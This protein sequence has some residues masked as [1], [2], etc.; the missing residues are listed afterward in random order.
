[1]A[2][3]TFGSTFLFAGLHLSRSFI[4][5]VQSLFE[6]SAYRP[7][8]LTPVALF[9]GP[10]FHTN[11]FHFLG[12]L[13]SLYFFGAL[14]EALLPRLTFAVIFGAGLWLSNP[15]TQA[16]LQ[17]W[18]PRIDP[19]G[20]AR[21]LAEW[22]YGMSNGVYALVGA[23]AAFL[24]R[25]GTVLVP[26]ILNAVFL[27]FA[28]NSWLSVHHLVGLFLGFSL[29]RIQFFSSAKRAARYA[30]RRARR[31]FSSSQRSD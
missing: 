19:T 27:I 26:F 12:N 20:Y 9:F 11:S 3:I 16:I 24:I 10:L 4:P 29:T 31:V 2:K 18:L 7:E 5:E 1:L 14:V 21:F 22:D 6:K 13:L 28:L 8:A 30:Q 25:P 15:L 17:P 23:F